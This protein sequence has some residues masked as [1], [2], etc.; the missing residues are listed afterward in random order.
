MELGALVCLPNTKPLCEKC[1]LNSFCQS[2]HHQTMLNFPTK[3]KMNERKIE[4]K[5]ILIFQ[6][7]NT[8]AIQKRP[9]KGLLASMYEFLWKSPKLTK[10]EVIQELKKE[11]IEVEAIE[12]LGEAKQIFSHIKWHMIGY[13]IIVKK[14]FKKSLWVTKDE[15]KIG[16]SN[17]VIVNQ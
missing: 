12:A 9:S 7:Q 10:E 14:P 16:V 17:S 6:Y 15:L 1:P 8:Y 13:H 2:Y 4:E 5:T 3:K 11:K